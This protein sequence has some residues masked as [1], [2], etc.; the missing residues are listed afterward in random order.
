MVKPL[1][2]MEIGSLGWSFFLW[3]SQYVNESFKNFTHL[4]VYFWLLWVSVSPR[5]LFPVVVS[6][7]Y[8]SC[9]VQAS[10]CSGSSYGAWDL[11]SW[12][13]VVAVLWLLSLVASQ[14]VESSWSRDL[15]HISCIGSQTPI[16]WSSVKVRK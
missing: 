11:G 8:S 10:H 14:Y 3:F 12:A 4:F 15:T 7:G 9:G 6:R 13:S 16:H 2:D 5:S 1:I